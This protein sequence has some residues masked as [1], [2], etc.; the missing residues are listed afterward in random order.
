EIEELERNGF[1]KD[2]EIRLR[3]KDG[4]EITCLDTAV[5]WRDKAGR[6]LGYIGTLR[7]ITEAKQ[8]EEELRRLRNLLANIIDSMPSVLAGVDVAGRVTQ[9]NQW[10]AEVTGVPAG[11]ALGRPISEVL[12]AVPG[13]FEGVAA[14][15]ETREVQR[16]E[17]VLWERGGEPRYYDVTA[18]PLEGGADRGAV[19]RLDD[20]THRVRIEDMIIQ[21][22]KMLS[23]GGLA[24]GMAHEINNP[25]VGIIHGA[26]NIIRRV[27]PDLEAN[28][29]LALE[30]GT[31]LDQVRAYLERR[32]IMQFLGG[33]LASGERAAKIVSNMLDF[34]RSGGS[35]K[36][37]A[38]LEE[39]LD[40]VVELSASDY[41]LK[42]RHDFLHINIVREYDAHLP[43]VLC[44]PTKIEQVILNLLKNSAQAM[45][46]KTYG[47]D[48]PIITLRTGRRGDQ[49][50][51]EVEDNG[52]GMDEAV[53][54]RVFEP[55]FTTKP[56]GEGTGLG[57]SVSYFIIVDSHQ[58][59]LNVES[60]P[61]TGAKFTIELP[62]PPAKRN[63][64]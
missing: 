25:L 47:D 41:D 52:P 50:F 7:D 10:A 54:R 56:A 64:R 3:H 30:C 45:N 37:A 60:S 9:W 40:K 1:I 31:R 44:E 27:S 62:L 46:H 42:K 36:K 19:I 17:K 20:V 22:E 15:I 58:G 51:I 33:I 24:A 11:Q 34:S 21:T 63:G 8:A 61:G 48:R 59:S 35:D 49:A 12:G 39:L 57:L 4:R 14:A 5:V 23:V 16:R 26:R 13:L 18:Y 28:R 2:K 55:F 29:L 38:R 53:R 32:Q 43:P 6:V